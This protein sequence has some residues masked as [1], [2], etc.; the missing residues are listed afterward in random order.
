M[1]PNCTYCNKVFND[2]QA[3]GN[4]IRTH[5]DDSDEDLDLS[6]PNKLS[7]NTTTYI[8][9]ETNVTYKKVHVE[10]KTNDSRREETTFI[11]D[12]I[13]NN[14]ENINIYFPIES[15]SE[16]DDNAEVNLSDDESM[17][18]SSDED[19]VISKL[20]YETNVDINEYDEYNA[21]YS[22]VLNG[23]KDIYQEFPFKEYAEFMHIITKF[24]VQD[25]LANVFIKFFNKYSNRKDKSLPSTSQ[26]GQTFIKNLQVPNLDWRREIIFRYKGIEYEFEYR[27]VLDGIHQILMNKD[28]IKDFI[29]ES[30]KNTSN[31]RQYIIM[32]D[33]DW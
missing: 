9:T 19:S 17:T 23:P 6:L 15:Q 29:F 27:T 26:V 25:S 21:L 16:E 2:R 32:Y 11:N 30:V 31:E 7:S 13:I 10:Q 8:S 4:H 18:E 1:M 28:I 20:S 24:H 3:L 22:G 33:S 12:E 14:N 5:L